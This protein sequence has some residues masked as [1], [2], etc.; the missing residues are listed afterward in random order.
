MKE[1]FRYYY[2]MDL[3]TSGKDLIRNH[4]SMSLYNHAAV[5]PEENM[6]P[7]GFFA[8]GWILVDGKKMSKSEGN[9]Y[10]LNDLNT[11]YGADASRIGLATAGDSIE[12]ANLAMEEVNQGILKLSALEMWLE[13][14]L[15]Q[16]ETLRTESTDEDNVAF[17]DSVFENELKKIALESIDFYESLVMRKVIENVF[18]GLQK[19]REDYCLNV[20]V[21]GMRRDLLVQ[22]VHL[23]LLFLYP[24]APHFAEV[25]WRQLFLPALGDQAKEFPE[26]ISY[27]TIPEYTMDQ[28]DLNVVGQFHFIKGLASEMN[29]TY[30]ALVK[31]AKKKKNIDLAALS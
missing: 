26:Y 14:N 19:L 12:D 9:F 20:G 31:K 21:H 23:Q 27:A 8:N 16:A 11:G 3:R 13:G 28:V 4:L 24:I 30:D 17:Y 5:W 18:F 10:T 7:R 15:K 6:L 2:P 25:K 22:Y 1:S 29:K